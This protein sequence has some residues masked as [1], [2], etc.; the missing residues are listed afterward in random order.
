M[1]FTFTWLIQ[2]WIEVTGAVLTL[3]FLYLEV[4]RKWTMWII[5]ILSGLFYVYINFDQQLYAMMG[6]RSYDVFVSIYGLYCWKYA[7]TKDN[8]ELPFRFI[9]KTLTFRLIAIGIAIYVV[10]GFIVTRFTDIPNPFSAGGEPVPFF[11]ELLAV[12]LSIL[13][14]WMAAKKI[15]ESWYLWMVVNPCSIALYVFKGMYPTTLLYVVFA[16]FSVV[17]YIQ[18]RKVA[19]KEK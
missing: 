15:V 12:T 2:N 19:V 11:I 4:S 14:V 8:S 7:K 18:W 9:N 16:I 5:G 17:G 1:N 13:A 3:I 6:L 10:L